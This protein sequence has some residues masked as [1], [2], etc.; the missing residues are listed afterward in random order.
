MKKEGFTLVEI[1]AVITILGIILM[2]AVPAIQ[3]ILENSKEDIGNVVVKR[4]EKGAEQYLMENEN[5]LWDLVNSG[6]IS[7]DNGYFFVSVDVL[8]EKGILYKDVVDSIKDQHSFPEGAGVKFTSDEFG[9][10]NYEFFVAGD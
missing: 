4:I 7:Y 2:I 1:I 6:E 9:N 8:I 5:Q 10:Y 3:T